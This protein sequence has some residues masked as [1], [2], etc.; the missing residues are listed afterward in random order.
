[1]KKGKFY[2]VESER[3]EYEKGTGYASYKS[4]VD[5]YIQDLVL[6][7]NITDIDY[8]I[9]ENVEVGTLYDEEN[10]TDIEIYQYFLCNLSEF[11]INSLK[12]LTGDNNDIIISYS[13]K[14]DCH[15]LM[16]DHLG[17]NWGYVGT[18]LKL[19]DD[20]NEVLD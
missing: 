15:V 6:C 17:T 9:W 8:S 18:S 7:N 5:R 4:L 12:E 13:E 16:V 20:I 2:L 14:L 10:E 11:E 3:N 19:T 1:M